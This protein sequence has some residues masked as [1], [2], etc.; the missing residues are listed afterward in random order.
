[1]NSKEKVIWESKSEDV[2]ETML[3]LKE[4]YGIGEFRTIELYGGDGH[5]LSNKMAEQSISFVGY[6]IDPE[7]EVD[8]KKNVLNG[9][10]N[11]K[12]SVKMMRT[13]KEGE[14]GGYN[15]ISTDAP[16]CIYGEDY[17]EHFEIIQYI[18]KLIN[19]GE[20]V[21][22]VFPVVPKPYNTDKKENLAWLK[23]REEFYKTKDINLDLDNIYTIY[24]YILK[25]QKLRILERCYICREYRNGVDWMYE[26]M[27]VLEK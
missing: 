24:D 7:K 15:L 20:I 3:K 4:Q 18:Y 14:L 16:I 5:T 21:L 25:K 8:F 23:R 19:Q 10:F 6:D 17:C 1:M 27:Y 2:I 13:M 26:F 22:Y 9:E 11:C 12:D